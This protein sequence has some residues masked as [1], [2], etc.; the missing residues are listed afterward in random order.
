M[1]KCSKCG[2]SLWRAS[3]SICEKCAQSERDA[4]TARALESE[5]QAQRTASIKRPSLVLTTEVA[6]SLPV[7]DRL[8]I[9]A[10][11]SVLGLNIF[12][13]LLLEVRDIVGGRSATLEKAISDAREQALDRLADAGARLG[14]DAIVG[15]SIT[16]SDIGGRGAMVLTVATGTAVTLEA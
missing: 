15:V 10:G 6:S 16:S 9:V 1:A 8:G 7:K 11:E 2:K 5:V 13:D 12:K 3:Q 4:A 14:A